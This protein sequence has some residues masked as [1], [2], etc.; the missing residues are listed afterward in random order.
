MKT[1][2]RQRRRRPVPRIDLPIFRVL[3]LAAVLVQYML[4]LRWL[5]LALRKGK[6]HGSKMKKG[7]VKS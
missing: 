2:R 5:I 6:D 4:E 3:L 1:V 7:K